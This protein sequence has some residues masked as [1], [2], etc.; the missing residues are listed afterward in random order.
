MKIVVNYLNFVF[1]IEV[2]TKFNDKFWNFVFQF[3]KN[4]K[5]H[6]GYTDYYPYFCLLHFNEEV[7]SIQSNTF[8]FLF[9]LFLSSNITYE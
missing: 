3:I 2:K 5:W 1:H 7:L 6:L 9:L 4:T 8:I